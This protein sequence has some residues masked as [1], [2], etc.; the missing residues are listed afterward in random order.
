[1]HKITTLDNGLR[2]VTQNMP[3]LETAYMGIFNSVGNRDEKKEINGAAHFLEHM[4]FKGTKTKTALEISDTIENV[5][6]NIN[7][8]T[9]KEIT[10]YTASLLGD[11]LH[12][13]IDILTDI[14]QN[15]TFAQEE[16]NR[17]RG[18]ILQEIGMYLDMPASMVDDYFFEKA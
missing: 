14:L 5:G 6:G 17:E 2:I 12:Y 18:T 16:L 13:G 15:S 7:A 8:Y 10:A 11:D 1:M 3:G 4:A 9:S